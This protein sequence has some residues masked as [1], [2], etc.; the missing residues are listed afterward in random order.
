MQRRWKTAIL[1]LVLALAAAAC[2]GGDDGGGGG[3]GGGDADTGGTEAAAGG[4]FSVYICEP[5]SLLPSNTNE[6]CG[7]EVLNALFKGL[8]DY[9]P[10]TSEPYN[11][12]AESIE[13]DDQMTWTI[14]LKDGWT[15][16]DGSP[17]TASSFVDAWNWAAYGP[18]AQGNAY[19]FE[20]IEGY[21]DVSPAE[22]GAE[23]T[24]EEMSGLEVVDDLTFRV[25]LKEPF[26]QFPLTLG[27]TAFYPLPEAFIDDP[28]AFEEAPIGNGPFM[29]EGQWERGQQIRAVRY[30][31]YAGDDPARADAVTFAIYSEINTAY[32]DLLAGN[33]DILDTVPPENIPT[34]AQDFGERY[35]EASSSAFTYLGFPLYQ[36]EFEDVNLRRALS[37]AIDREAIIEAI[38]PDWTPASSYVSPVVQGA[39]E[40]PCGE[41]CQYD[42]EQARQLFEEAGGF[43]GPLT[44]WFNSGAGHEGWTEAVANQWREALGITD[45]QFESLEFAEYLGLLDAHEITGPF[46]LG[47]V[48]DYPSPQNYLQPL[49]ST[50]GS[51]NNFG[52]SNPDVDRLLQ[53]GNA[54]DSVEAGI[55]LYHQAEDLILEDMPAIPISFER[56]AAAHS[57]RVRNVVIDGFE[58]IDLPNVEVVE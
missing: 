45:I 34:A 25:T 16:H 46:R 22:E 58:R 53:E 55:E 6:V 10:Q 33:L 8:V 29:I 1:M 42:P 48:M 12:V 4:E 24:A 44:I 7:A 27:Y 36:P 14:T 13:S 20:N 40:D 17:V 5:E 28:E 43:D 38:R 26:S 47:W 11:V 41:W 49:Y 51:S 9:D 18:N 21:D 3:D 31:D 54:A 30:D 52:Y 57:E 2:G 19:F 56:L 23:P 32:N 15:F 39:R 37:M 50:T 35:I